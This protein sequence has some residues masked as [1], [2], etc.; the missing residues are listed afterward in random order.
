MAGRARVDCGERA[1]GRD[2]VEAEVID[3]DSATERK[4]LPRHDVVDGDGNLAGVGKGLVPVDGASM[5]A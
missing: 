4:F 2:G 1:F 3:D 5:K